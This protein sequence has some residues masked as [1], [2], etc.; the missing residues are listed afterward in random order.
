[1]LNR[2]LRTDRDERG[3]IPIAI[4]VIFVLT[5]ALGS[6]ML[7]INGSLELT[8]TDQNRT[9]AFQFANAGIDQALYRI[10][11]AT[12]PTTASGSY[13]PALSGSRVVSFTDAISVGSSTFSIVATKTPATQDRVWQVRSTGTDPSGR[14]RLAIATVAATSLFEEGFFTFHQFYLTGNQDTPVAY[15]SATCPTASPSCELA[16]PVPGALGTNSTFEG[17]A[18][19][20]AAFVNDWTSFRMYGRATQAA[21][22]TACDSGR[23]GTTPKVV[24]IT[25]QKA[26]DTPAIPAGVQGCPYG[27]NISNT[28]IAPGDYS[29]G[30]LTFTG[31]ITVSGTGN[32][33]FWVNGDIV[34]ASGSVVNRN[35]P[36]SRVQL[37]QTQQAA[38]GGNLCDAEVWALLYTPSLA[39]DCNG[40]HQPKI[41]GAVV[42]DYHSGTGN[43]FDFHWDVDSIDAVGNGKYVVRNWRECPPGTTDC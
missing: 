10:D 11:S 3:S 32:A 23:C 24:A 41:Y 22:D 8:R 38:T 17:S 28:A 15:H 31:M 29:C 39:I 36:P 40:S 1:M 7:S 18:A 9:N 19:T 37:F 5:I 16:K 4:I 6:M 13:V 12:V 43:H 20:T 26:I 33:R 42:A 25:D 14:Q 27:G 2:L 30:N 35:Q 34:F 21:A